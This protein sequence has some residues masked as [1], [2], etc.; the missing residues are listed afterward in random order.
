MGI[1]DWLQK[2]GNEKSA[3]NIVDGLRPLVVAVRADTEEAILGVEKNAALAARLDKID[4]PQALAITQS[5][6][7][8]RWRDRKANVAS[9]QRKLHEDLAVWSG[10]TPERALNDVILPALL[11]GKLIAQSDPSFGPVLVAAYRACE[12]AARQ[13][14]VNL[15]TCTPPEILKL[16]EDAGDLYK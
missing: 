4:G 1:I 6:D 10:L 16:V 13:K 2:K 14:G 5:Q 11:S 9:A 3:A 12:A 15:D 7:Y 8:Q